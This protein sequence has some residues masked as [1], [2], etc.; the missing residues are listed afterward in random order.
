M[1]VYGVGLLSLQVFCAVVTGVIRLHHATCALVGKAKLAGCGA[2]QAGVG[3]K[4][5]RMWVGSSGL[6]PVRG[7]LPVAGCF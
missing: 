1:K 7:S 3:L 2:V 5:G 4:F 6:P